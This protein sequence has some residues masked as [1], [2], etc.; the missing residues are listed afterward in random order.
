MTKKADRVEH[1][2]VD[3]NRLSIYQA[4]HRNER[5]TASSARFFILVGSLNSKPPSPS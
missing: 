3:Q 4:R 5:I 1:A 2:P